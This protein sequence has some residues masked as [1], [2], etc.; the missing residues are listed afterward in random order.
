MEQI[1]IL[2]KEIQRIS[3]ELLNTLDINEINNVLDNSDSNN[4]SNNNSDNNNNNRN[5]NN[6]ENNNNNN[7]NNKIENKYIQAYKAI[8]SIPGSGELV[9]PFT[10]ISEV[11]DITRFKTKKHFV[12]Y[13]GLDPTVS[14]SGKYK[15]NKKI[16]KKGNKHLRHTFTLWAERVLKLMPEYR[17]NTMI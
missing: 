12:S 7:D 15:R 6:N 4:N 9:T 3:N 17:K 1:E 5:R 16:S 8:T 13:I 11:G 10:I 14:Q 2:E